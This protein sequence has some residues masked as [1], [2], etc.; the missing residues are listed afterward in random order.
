M[1][2]P[3]LALVFT[4]GK[5]SVSSP[6]ADESEFSASA[7]PAVSG[8]MVPFSAPV[9][10]SGPASSSSSNNNGNQVSHSASVSSASAQPPTDSD[11]DESDSFVS[12]PPASCTTPARRQPTNNQWPPSS[13]Q[14]AT[15]TAKRPLT[16]HRP[17]T[18]SQ[19]DGPV[20]EHIEP[21]PEEAAAEVQDAD[22]LFYQHQR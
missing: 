20:E 13:N 19:H 17:A 22:D 1:E 7:A 3:W 11:N 16:G 9:V 21:S 5:L 6:P 8:P 10:T 12:E 18:R 14:R 4:C 2:I 15:T